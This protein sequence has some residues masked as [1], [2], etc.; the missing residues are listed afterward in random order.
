MARPGP[1]PNTHFQGPRS[2]LAPMSNQL[3]EYPTSVQWT[4]GRDGKGSVTSKHSN[5]TI[6]IA[7]PP[8]FQGPGG[9]ASPEEL[10]TCAVASCYTMTFGFTAWISKIT[11][12]RMAAGAT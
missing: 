1:R 12:T 3:H 8:E 9:G 10:L 2:K 4:G 5:T 11:V 7:V 6:D